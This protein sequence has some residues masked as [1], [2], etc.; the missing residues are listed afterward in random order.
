M[1]YKDGTSVKQI[2]IVIEPNFVCTLHLSDGRHWDTMPLKGVP[3]SVKHNKEKLES[4]VF[5]LLARSLRSLEE[6][7]DET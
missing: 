4:A 6:H 7:K 1:I 2:E 3:P 5:N